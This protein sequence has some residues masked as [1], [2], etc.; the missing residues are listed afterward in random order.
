MDERERLQRF[1]EFMIAEFERFQKG[2]GKWRQSS[3]AFA[4]YL[5]TSSASTN[6]WLLG[7]RMP[8]LANALRIAKTVGRDRGRQVFE[9]LG[10]PVLYEINDPKLEYIV[11][12]WEL[13]DADTKQEFLGAVE[14]EVTH[15]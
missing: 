13:L 4:K 7:Q 9:I 11:E 14:R 15:K 5:G 1:Q 2:S 12:V 10:Y 3:N 6:Q 8:D